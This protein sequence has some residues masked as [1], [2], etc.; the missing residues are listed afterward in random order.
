MRRSSR[1]LSL[2]FGALLAFAADGGA[3]SD[4]KAVKIAAT[5]SPWAVVKSRVRVAGT[6]TPHPAGITVTLQQRQGNGLAF[7]RR[8]TGARGR[9]FS[10]VTQPSKLGL[11]AYPVVTAKGTS[12]VGAS[13]RLPVR[14]LHWQ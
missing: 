6:V 1:A 2:A 5:A 7:A 4:G 13:A 9:Y 12:Y 14:V 3:S 10:F 8:S 11:A